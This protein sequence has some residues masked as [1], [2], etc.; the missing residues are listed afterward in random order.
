MKSESMKPGNIFESIPEEFDDELF[1][2]IIQ[3]G[4]VKI[5]RIVSKGHASPKSGWYDQDHNEWIIVLKGEAIITLEN[6]EKIN[7]KGGC[8]L[9]IPA[10]TKHKVTWTKPKT[11]TVWL[12]VRY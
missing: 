7:L 12:A 1:D 5:E 8:H 2:L 10:H 9:N 3:H 4:D 11:D 6:E